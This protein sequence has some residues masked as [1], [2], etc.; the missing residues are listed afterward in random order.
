MPTAAH[1]R[2]SKPCC[3]HQN[4]S[5][6]FKVTISMKLVHTFSQSA[7]LLWSACVPDLVLDFAAQYKVDVGYDGTCGTLWFSC[8]VR[9]DTRA[10][11]L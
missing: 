10:C 5:Q 8:Y 4:Q 3:V 6:V 1:L 9:F 2:V 11:W 7:L